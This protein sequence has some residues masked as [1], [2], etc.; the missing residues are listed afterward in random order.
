MD[1]YSGPKL[2]VH[3]KQFTG[4]AVAVNRQLNA[5]LLDNLHSANAHFLSPQ[6]NKI[7]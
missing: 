5:L 7:Q 4:S 3:E 1:G 2:R 6:F